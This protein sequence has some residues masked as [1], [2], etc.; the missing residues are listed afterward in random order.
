VGFEFHCTFKALNGYRA[1][2]L[3]CRG[4]FARQQHQPEDFQ[5]IC[6]DQG[7]GLRLRQ[8]LSQWTNIDQ[9]A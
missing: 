7:S 6:P 3:V 2:C 9:V 1:G 4:L 8:I 5:M